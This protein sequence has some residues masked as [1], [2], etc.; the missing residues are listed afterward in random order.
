MRWPVVV[1]LTCA[2]GVCAPGAVGPALAASPKLEPGVHVDPGSPAGKQYQ[3]PISSAR[4]EAAGGAGGTNGT[5]PAFGVGITSGGSGPGSGSS[6]G[7]AAGSA[8][9]A[10]SG[11]TAGRNRHRAASAGSAG[12]TAA[13]VTGAANSN[14]DLTGVPSSSGEGGSGAWPVLAAGGLLVLVIGG[15]GG[16]ALRRRALRPS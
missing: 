9:H 14:A 11:A 8:H 1:L 2:F 4:S 15:G 13:A 5:A 10:R 3:I 6:G 7:A 16:L 12:S